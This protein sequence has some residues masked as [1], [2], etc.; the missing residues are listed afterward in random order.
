MIVNGRATRQTLPALCVVFRF[1]QQIKSSMNRKRFVD[2][3]I[4]WVTSSAAVDDGV[5]TIPD[6]PINR[7]SLEP[8][9][10]LGS[11]V[12]NSKFAAKQLGG[13]ERFLGEF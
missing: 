2:D 8:T 10:K 12:Q 11:D 1:P 7:L 4:R 5:T 13:T 3:F 9:H 6:R